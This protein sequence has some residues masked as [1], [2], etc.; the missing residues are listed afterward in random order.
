[1]SSCCVSWWELVELRHWQKWFIFFTAISLKWCKKRTIWMPQHMKVFHEVWLNVPLRLEF[2]CVSVETMMFS[3]LQRADHHSDV[4]KFLWGLWIDS[5]ASFGFPLSGCWP[6]MWCLLLRNVSAGCHKKKQHP[7]RSR[8]VL[9]QTC[10]LLKKKKV[11]CFPGKE[12]F[13]QV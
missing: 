4:S 10:D 8:W 1:M 6:K 7:D 3:R 9:N 2:F 13:R 12:R 5:T 11:I